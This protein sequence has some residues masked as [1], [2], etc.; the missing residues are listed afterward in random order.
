[1]TDIRDGSAPPPRSKNPIIHTRTRAQQLSY[2]EQQRV[3]KW[4]DY[5]IFQLFH[6]SP[7]YLSPT[8][9]SIIPETF[10]PH[11]NWTKNARKRGR[12]AP[13]AYTRMSPRWTSSAGGRVVKKRHSESAS[14]DA[15]DCL[16][17]QWRQRNGQR[18][19]K[20]RMTIQTDTQGPRSDPKRSPETASLGPNGSER[21]GRC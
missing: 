2:F 13:A 11:E 14:I 10:Y 1:M 19:E 21:K 8:G 6:F 4:P 15:H 18:V 20:R 12:N 5:T 3:N 7:R 17:Q 9:D 16:E